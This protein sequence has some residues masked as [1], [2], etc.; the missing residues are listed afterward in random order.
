MAEGDDPIFA[1]HYFQQVLGLRKD[2]T[3]VPAY[4]LW[5]SWGGKRVEE[6]LP[7]MK[8]DQARFESLLAGERVDYAMT[9]ILDPL[10]Q[11][12]PVQVSANLD[13][14]NRCY[15]SLQP[16]VQTTG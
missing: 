10:A 1:V 8:W 13:L 9:R 15:F 14:L 11:G 2:I 5:T 3:L 6:K 16:I 7:G 4:Y 12:R